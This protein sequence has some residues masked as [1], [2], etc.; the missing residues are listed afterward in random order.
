MRFVNQ[1]SGEDKDPN[2]THVD[3]GSKGSGKAKPDPIRIGAIQ[4]TTCSRCGARGHLKSECHA[5]LGAQYALIE[6][7]IEDNSRGQQGETQ[8]CG[9]DSLVPGKD[10]ELVK[11]A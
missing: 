3:S 1:R 7:V 5:T 9:R 2:N 4:P 6:E 11:K 8:G 10:P